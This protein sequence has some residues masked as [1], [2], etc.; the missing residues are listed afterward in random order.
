[1]QKKGLRPHVQHRR[2]LQRHRLRRQLQRHRHQQWFYL[3]RHQLRLPLLPPIPWYTMP[4][5]KP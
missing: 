3:E 2:L 4:P 5:S 1:M